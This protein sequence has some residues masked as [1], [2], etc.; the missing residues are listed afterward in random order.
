M[1]LYVHLAFSLH[2]LQGLGNLW[3]FPPQSM[4]EQ[5][6]NIWDHDEKDRNDE[7]DHRN[8]SFHKDREGAVANTERT[9]KDP[10][11]KIAEHHAQ[12]Q[13]CRGPLGLVEEIAYYSKDNGNANV[14]DPILHR[15]RP[16]ER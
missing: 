8:R 10:F 15:V 9:V 7:Q 5:R 1:L 2:S 16:D 13:T 6:G 3:L 11:H 4:R 12:D 14:L